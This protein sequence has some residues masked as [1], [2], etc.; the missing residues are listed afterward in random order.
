MVKTP[1]RVEGPGEQRTNT[2][3]SLHVLGVLL[4]L[5][6]LSGPHPP[7]SVLCKSH[8]SR[9]R[10]LGSGTPSLAP[11]VSSPRTPPSLVS[12]FRCYFGQIL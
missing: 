4:A 6:A 3:G 12:S 11:P 9:V 8:E 7:A 5:S 2:E 10:R 1:R